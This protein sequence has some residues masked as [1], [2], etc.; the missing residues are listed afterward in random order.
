MWFSANQFGNFVFN[1]QFYYGQDIVHSLWA[2]NGIVN[3]FEMPADHFENLNSSISPA[4]PYQQ[5]NQIS[6]A[7]QILIF[8]KLGF[9]VVSEG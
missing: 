6:S 7:A 8:V 4:A 9:L 3:L 2:A 5:L 1:N